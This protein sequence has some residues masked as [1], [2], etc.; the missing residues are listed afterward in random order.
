MNIYEISQTA[1]GGYDTYDSAVVVAADEDAARKTHQA[2]YVGRTWSDEE[3]SWCQ[4]GRPVYGSFNGW[5]KPNNVG[6]RLIGV[7]DDAIEPGVIVAS[8]NAG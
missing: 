8:F 7:A 1:N 3:D 2:S 5:T 4:N 6:V